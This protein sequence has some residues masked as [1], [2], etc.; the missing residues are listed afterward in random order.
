VTPR[1]RIE[2]IGALNAA[3]VPAG[4][5]VA[6]VIPGLTDHEME[7]ILEAAADAGAVDAGYTLLRLPLEVKD[8]FAEWL[9]AHAPLKARHVL[10]LVRQMRGGR[11]NDPA[12]GS[13]MRGSG[14]MAELLRRRF[15]AAC[16]RLGLPRATGEL[17]TSLFRPPPV[18]GDQLSL[19]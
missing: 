4:V 2:T 10:S 9:E 18:P 12:F 13:R 11:L 15:K 17:D 1:R 16:R 6:P 3:G 8:L 14:A 5:M 19:L 7:R